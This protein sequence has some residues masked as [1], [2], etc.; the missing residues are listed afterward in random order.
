MTGK[1]Y[2]LFRGIAENLRTSRRSHIEWANKSNKDSPDQ[3]YYEGVAQ[4]LKDGYE[5]IERL[6]AELNS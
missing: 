5:A 4:G 6:L 1:E 3:K 2:H